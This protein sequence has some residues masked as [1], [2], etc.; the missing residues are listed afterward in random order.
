MVRYSPRQALADGPALHVLASVV[1]T[2]G[3]VT[4]LILCIRI[5]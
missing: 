3:G 4:L 1:G 5:S 2:V